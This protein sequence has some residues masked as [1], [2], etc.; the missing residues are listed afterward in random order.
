MRR[1]NLPR[2][3]RDG[4]K[5]NHSTARLLSHT[6]EVMQDPSLW[7]PPLEV[8]LVRT[9]DLRPLL[10][11][12]QTKLMTALT[13]TD[14]GL[15]LDSVDAQGPGS[16]QAASS[17]SYSYLET[18][19]RLGFNTVP[20]HCRACPSCDWRCEKTPKRPLPTSRGPSAD[21]FRRHFYTKTIDLPRQARDKH[22]TRENSK[23]RG[24]FSQGCPAVGRRSSLVGAPTRS[25]G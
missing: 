10:G 24:R 16:G 4:R 8:T 25:A 9:P 23:K 15:F 12:G 2:H 17:S 7:Q 14:S 1:Y 19:S 13:W 11:V 3:A 6:Q 18:Y 5:D 21:S 22:S 20:G